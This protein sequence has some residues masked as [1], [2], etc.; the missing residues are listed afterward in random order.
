MTKLDTA[1]ESRALSAQEQDLRRDLKQAV[2]GLTSLSR[3][4]ARQRAR[5]RQLAEG[6]AC[7]LYFHL[8]ACH[9]RRKNYLFSLQHNGH[10]FTEEEAK[11]DI[12]FAYY[13]DLLGTSFTRV[14][15][16]DLSQLALPQ[17][18]LTEQAARFS[19]DEIMQAIRCSPAN[20][21]PGPDGLGPTFYTAAW[22][23]V[24]A[25]MVCAFHAL[26]EMDFRSFHH[27]NED[28]MVLLQ[29]TQCPAGLRDYR[30]IS[31]VHSVGKLFSKCLALRL[32]PR[33]GELINHNQSAFIKGRQIHENF[34][35]VQL[36]CRWLHARHRPM[37]L[38]KIDLAKAFDSVA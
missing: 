8:Q 19:T 38:L 3:T 21:A 6:D 4:M 34:K 32:A 14:H 17:L 37:V 16:I 23:V 11:A 36:T 12:V 35:T 9:R 30:P 1:Q 5:N 28:V 24:G 7:T 31:L 20:R 22:E 15:C 27:L 13:D 2:L 33:M 29:K 10:T 26:W 18:D 25:D